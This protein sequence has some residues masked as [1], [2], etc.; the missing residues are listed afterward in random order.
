MDAC[1]RV[2]EN[3]SKRRVQAGYEETRRLLGLCEQLEVAVET[4]DAVAD[5]LVDDVTHAWE[6]SDVKVSSEM[7]AVLRSR[8]DKALQHIRDTTNPDY[9]ANETLRRNLLIQMEVAAGI[10][11]PAEDK[12]RR[13][14]YQLEH[15]Q[16]VSYT[17]LTLPT[18]PYV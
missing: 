3:A 13:M 18:T 14:Q 16:P 9:Q 8:R 6:A 17:H 12:A 7:G 4:P 1:S 2:Q 10:D 5:T 15:L 11:T